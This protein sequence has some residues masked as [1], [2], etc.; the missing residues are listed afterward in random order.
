M[1]ETCLRGCNWRRDRFWHCRISELLGLIIWAVTAMPLIASDGNHVELIATFHGDGSKAFS[2]GV[3]RA[4][5]NKQAIWEWDST[6]CPLPLED[7]ARI[8]RKWL[9]RQNWHAKVNVRDIRLTR[10]LSVAPVRWYYIFHFDIRRLAEKQTKRKWID[11]P[12]PCS[13]AVLLD[14]TVVEAKRARSTRSSRNV[15]EKSCSRSLEA[16]EIFRGGNAKSLP[17][18]RFPIDPSA[19]RKGTETSAKQRTGMRLRRKWRRSSVRAPYPAINE[20]NFVHLAQRRPT[21]GATPEQRRTSHPTFRIFGLHQQTVIPRDIR[22]R[23][24]EPAFRTRP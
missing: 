19:A 9:N 5:M 12:H 14:G 15:S 24:C 23:Q 20:S 8:V 10:C 3:S 4:L 1:L 22:K 13:V 7:A 2:G 16:P 11:S 21:K 17:W 6:P 18:I